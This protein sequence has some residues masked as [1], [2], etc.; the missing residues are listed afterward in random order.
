MGAISVS[1][2]LALSLGSIAH[3]DT[4]ADIARAE[5]ELADLESQ[6]DDLAR[7][8]EASWERQYELEARIA[9]LLDAQTLVEIEFTSALA[10][11][12]STAIRL[13]MDVAAGEGMSAML[14]TNGEIYAAAVQYLST[15][16]A[17]SEQ[18]L[19]RLTSIATEMENRRIEL[20]ASLEAQAETEAA[21][22]VLAADVTEALG[23]QADRLSELEGLRARE[24]FLA[25]STTTTTSPPTTI[26]AS[27][28]TSVSPSAP[29]TTTTTSP[30]TTTTTTSPT[31][32]TTATTTTT[33][34]PSSPTTGGSCPVA[35]PVTYVDSWG[36]PRSGGRA[37]Q[38]V[39]M[40]SARGTPIAAIYSGVIQRMSNS[41]LGG[42]TLWM[43]ST[44]GD[45]F[46]YAHLDGY[47]DGIA[48][49]VAVNEGQIIG[50]NG[51]SGNAPD[52]L[53][54]LH[55]EYHP[56]GGA[57]ANPY[58]LVRSICG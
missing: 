22:A 54:H 26:A 36:A 15:A 17:D 13:Y 38:G 46:Y 32:T 57:A 43:L 39:D 47:A 20:D 21:L 9:A 58:P 37:H 55:F 31:T 28:T 52:Y 56:G 18:A 16:A 40:I 30:E 41:A 50:Y 7:R 6:A 25:T 27:T 53:P 3:A 8:I 49:G 19:A 29:E 14:A 1:L 10:D 11:L 42:I 48:P 35:G 33:L 2:A 12:E 5:A 45:Q 24:L 51:S 34:P 23:A 44:A 4:E